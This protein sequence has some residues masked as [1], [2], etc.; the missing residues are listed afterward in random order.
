MTCSF[1]SET[2]GDSYEICLKIVLKE[3]Y[4]FSD[5]QAV[6][7]KKK[8]ARGWDLGLSLGHG[9]GVVRLQPNEAN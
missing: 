4:L 3:K 7:G 8:E 2:S 9:I 1:L 6:M 5:S